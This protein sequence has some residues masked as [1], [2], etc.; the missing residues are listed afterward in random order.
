M[1]RIRQHMQT[2]AYPDVAALLQLC[3]SSDAAYSS[4][5]SRLSLSLSI[6]QHTSTDV[7]RS[8]SYTSAY[9]NRCFVVCGC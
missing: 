8:L 7:V 1:L 9:V 4:P 5:F 2:P 6:R 3:C